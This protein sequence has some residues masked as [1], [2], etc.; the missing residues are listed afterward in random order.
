M[1]SMATG[2]HIQKYNL[3][4]ELCGINS[5]FQHPDVFTIISVFYHRHFA[6]QY[7]L[8]H[9]SYAVNS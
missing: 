8:S 6:H 2:S 7:Q 4:F 9:A 5:I 3:E 1:V